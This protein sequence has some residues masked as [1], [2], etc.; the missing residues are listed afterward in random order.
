M[1]EA[2]GLL[3]WMVFAIFLRFF[4]VRACSSKYAT[5]PNLAFLS[6]VYEAS[7]RHI[8]LSFKLSGCLFLLG[9][10][11]PMDFRNYDDR[12]E[13]PYESRRTSDHDHH[14]REQRSDNYRYSSARMR[15]REGQ[16]D[17]PGEFDVPVSQ[18][19]KTDYVQL[20]L[21]R[22]QATRARPPEPI[23]EDR[24]RKISPRVHMVQQ[25]SQK[26]KRTRSESP[27][28]NHPTE[29]RSPVALRFEK[30]S[31]HKTRL[32]KYIYKPE[33]DRDRRRGQGREHHREDSYRSLDD[34]LKHKR[35]E[36]QHAVGIYTIFTYGPLLMLFTSQQR[37]KDYVQRADHGLPH[38]RGSKAK[39]IETSTRRSV[40]TSKTVE[41]RSKSRKQ[42]AEDKELEALSA[43]FARRTEGERTEA[44]KTRR[45][46]RR[47][48]RYEIDGSRHL[49]SHSRK[50]RPHNLPTTSLHPSR[51]IGSTR[52]P[53]L[54]SFEQNTHVSGYDDNIT[55][56]PPAEPSSRSTT[57][58]TWSTS[59]RDPKA[60]APVSND[61]TLEKPHGNI[62]DSVR[63]V[64][65]HERKLSSS[66]VGLEDL[67]VRP[68]S[69][70]KHRP[71]K[72]IVYK[73]AEVQT[74]FGV[75]KDQNHQR[76]NTRP[77][78]YQDS[79]VMTADDNDNYN[80]RERVAMLAT[81]SVPDRNTRPMD[82]QPPSNTTAARPQ[83]GAPPQSQSQAQPQ[84]WVTYDASDRLDFRP[85]IAART[86]LPEGGGQTYQKP[87][88]G[89]AVGRCTQLLP[90]SRIQAVRPGRQPTTLRPA[91]ENLSDLR[92]CSSTQPLHVDR[93]GP[94]RESM[95]EY[96]NRIEQEALLYSTSNG[97]VDEL[98][99]LGPDLPENMEQPQLDFD[100]YPEG[101]DMLRP[102][103]TWY[104]QH[105]LPS[106]PAHDQVRGLEDIDLEQYG[107]GIEGQGNQLPRLW[108]D[109]SRF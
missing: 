80:L 42:H 84:A 54:A 20:W 40:H 25:A 27:E 85:F 15:R 74:S 17:Y 46:S 28:P 98:Q 63:K 81:G 8:Q 87:S 95:E 19:K 96:I 88:V 72:R 7:S 30:R 97:E 78:Q 43:F 48:Q 55:N 107:Q 53:S 23:P 57:Y 51:S 109:P 108:E 44:E 58:F 86:S 70:M 101:N 9:S 104:D 4:R 60:R 12:D 79:A 3:L 1:G 41:P 103:I 29:T 37:S 2:F 67:K 6:F 83:I 33:L 36:Y 62:R 100:S 5:S 49:V 94:P 73:D 10:I 50:Q 14:R 39:G 24:P 77:P 21:Q 38:C 16:H 102:D 26:K 45:G 76:A 64:A 32:D 65:F 34:G 47:E 22:S 91:A 11:R 69:R 52:Q 61:S 66:N 93:R 106:H 90:P 71:P 18:P 68:T 105:P 75:E 13:Y 31:R 99:P 56:I 59:D 92:V 89:Q 35:G 82:E